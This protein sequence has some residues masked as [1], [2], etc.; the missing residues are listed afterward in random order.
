MGRAGEYS[1][2]I[3]NLFSPL[4]ICDGFIDV[5]VL[6]IERAHNHG[7]KNAAYNCH[8]RKSSTR[9]KTSHT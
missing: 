1:E 3:R 4:D 9:L 2:S 8:K 7:L 5:T 6:G